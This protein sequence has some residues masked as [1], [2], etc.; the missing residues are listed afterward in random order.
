MAARNTRPRK[1]GCPKPSLRLTPVLAIT[2]EGEARRLWSHALIGT[3][4]CVALL[5]QYARVGMPHMPS[6]DI[7]RLRDELTQV[8]ESATRQ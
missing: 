2:T 8:I 5:R 4:T 7:R 1:C 6:D 3:S